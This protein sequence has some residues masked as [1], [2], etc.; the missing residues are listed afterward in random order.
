MG[1]MVR[2][3]MPAQ[4]QSTGPTG[5]QQHTCSPHSFHLYDV[6]VFGPEHVPMIA[7]M[8][9]TPED[10]KYRA[11][12]AQAT[13][14]GAF[15]QWTELVEFTLNQA[16]SARQMACLLDRDRA[17]V[18]ARNREAVRALHDRRQATDARSRVQGTLEQIRAVM[19]PFT[20]KFP[21]CFG[22][23]QKYAASE[24]RHGGSAG[25][26]Y[27]RGVAATPYSS[28]LWIHYVDWLRRQE[29]TDPTAIRQCVT[30]NASFASC[31]CFQCDV[32]SR[33][34]SCADAGQNIR[35]PCLHS[36]DA[37]AGIRRAI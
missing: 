20:A 16:R 36:R 26:V 24:E 1:Q 22:Y 30:S 23:W 6:I 31:I 5:G 17:L 8:R 3:S 32:L 15:T 37:E 19:E 14:S 21:L 7:G 33:R 10:E 28:K 35:L 11:L 18:H 2:C 25:Q 34:S 4:M 13:A 27:E 12:W 29:S 9:E